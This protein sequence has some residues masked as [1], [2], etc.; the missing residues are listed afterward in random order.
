MVVVGSDLGYA[1]AT[2]SLLA[3]IMSVVP[4]LLPVLLAPKLQPGRAAMLLGGLAGITLFMRPVCHSV[5][6]LYRPINKL[7]T[8]RATMRPWFR[9]QRKHKSGG[10]GGEP[11]EEICCGRGLACH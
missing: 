8:P 10:G 9:F 2:T 5:Q 6:S 1:T 11:D 7:T 4:I 3:K